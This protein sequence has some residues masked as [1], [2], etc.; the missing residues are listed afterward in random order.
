LD[1]LQRTNILIDLENELKNT[2]NKKSNQI[3][4][5]IG[6]LNNFNEREIKVEIYLNVTRFGILYRMLTLN[7]GQSPMSLRHQIEILYSDYFITERDGII[8]LR[9]AFD[10]KKTIKFG[11]YKFS[12]IVEGVTSFIDGSEFTL[13]RYDLLDYVKSLK[14]LSLEDKKVDIFNSFVSTYHL[15]LKVLIEKSNSWIFDVTNL[16]SDNLNYFPVQRVDQDTKKEVRVAPFG[17]SAETIFL[18]SQIY[19]GLGSALSYLKQKGAISE[20]N[21]LKK[22]IHNIKFESTPKEAFDNMV[23][24]LEQ[25]RKESK[26]IGESQRTFFKFFFIS[27]FNNHDMDSYLIIEK[28]ID[29][30]F[31]KTI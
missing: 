5:D 17:N 25:I 8:L 7:T 29:S 10:N 16:G 13:D 19:T 11:Q 1:G 2:N 26:K 30:A 21:D 12:E 31:R 3:I 18:K 20:I 9:D 23:V 28:A 24:R 14:K 22:I 4:E 27:L 15:L 6:L